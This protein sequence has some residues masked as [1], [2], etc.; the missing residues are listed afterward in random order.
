MSINKD[1]INEVMKYFYEISEIPRMSGKE[2]KIA[3]YIEKF[4]KEGLEIYIDGDNIVITTNEIERTN[5]YCFTTETMKQVIDIINV[6]QNGVYFKDKYN[7]PLVS[8]NLGKIENDDHM[9]KLCFS[10]RSNREEIEK[11]LE[12]ELEKNVHQYKIQYRKSELL[13]Y[14]HKERSEFIDKCKTI[15]KQHFERDP[16]VIDMHI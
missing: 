5:D 6:I 3:D 1:D 10:I 13:G 12:C 11:N 2:E 7:N 16:K 15:Y 4:A 9:V 14:E 8:V